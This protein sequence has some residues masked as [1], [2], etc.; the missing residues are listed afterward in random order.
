MFNYFLCSLF[1]SFRKVNLC[2]QAILVNI[3]IYIYKH[4]IGVLVSSFCSLMESIIH[5]SPQQQRATLQYQT[6]K[7]AFSGRDRVSGPKIR[8][9]AKP[10]AITTWLAA[11][12]TS[13]PFPRPYSSSPSLRLNMP[14]VVVENSNYR[15]IK[16]SWLHL[17]TFY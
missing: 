1:V 9:S 2:V 14:L 8:T 17:N 11:S 13:T 5:N 12:T 10:P 7:K 6:V 3:Y 15:N 16:L 4:T